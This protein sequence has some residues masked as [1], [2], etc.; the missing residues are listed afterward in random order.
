MK[1]GPEDIPEADESEDDI[2]L[3]DLEP[4]E[5]AEPDEEEE[6]PE[7]EEDFSLY[8]QVKFE[9]NEYTELKLE[10]LSSHWLYGQPELTK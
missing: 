8:A 9:N 3:Q 6:L 4:E 1:A 10:E 7:I 5:T 2:I